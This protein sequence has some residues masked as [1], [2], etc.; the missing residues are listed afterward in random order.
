MP[1]LVTGNGNDGSR[2]SIRNLLQHS[3]G[4]CRLQLRIC[5]SKNAVDWEREA[6]AGPTRLQELVKFAMPHPPL[7]LP[8]PHQ[9]RFSY[10]NTNFVLAGLIIERA[11]GRSWREEVRDRIV[12]KLRLE[13]TIAPGVPRLPCT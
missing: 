7:W 5:R 4:T 12:R 1:G 6:P 8:Q 3:S 13:N 2:I 10:A 11:T 9:Q